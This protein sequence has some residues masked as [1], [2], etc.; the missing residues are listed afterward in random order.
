M[1]AKQFEWGVFYEI[2]VDGFSHDYKDLEHVQ[3]KKQGGTISGITRRLDY[4]KQLNVT[5]VLFTTPPTLS[6]SSL[7]SVTSQM[8]S[9]N[10]SLFMRL[11]E[12]LEAK[13]EVFNSE[14][15]GLF[16]THPLNNSALCQSVF[17]QLNKFKKRPILIADENLG[18]ALKYNSNV[19]KTVKWFHDYIAGYFTQECL[20]MYLSTKYDGV[21]DYAGQRIAHK[22]SKERGVFRFL[23]E[24]L[25]AFFYNAHVY[26]YPQK[27]VLVTP[28]FRSKFSKDEM[29]LTARFPNPMLIQMGVE[30]NQTDK[31]KN[32]LYW[33]AIDYNQSAKERFYYSMKLFQTRKDTAAGISTIFTIKNDFL[34]D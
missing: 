33:S 31:H 2:F 23:P 25:S 5:S 12:Q 27:T 30:L 1:I 13:S 9:N 29:S 22:Y 32:T 6:L 15:D 34:I 26:L 24:F 16:I 21:V 11:T 14:V 8:H 28:T 20:Q 18:E 4:L 17:S 7:K 3:S 19:L 10:I